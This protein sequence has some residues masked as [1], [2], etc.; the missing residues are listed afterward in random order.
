MTEDHMGDHTR[1]K[2][3]VLVDLNKFLDNGMISTMFVLKVGCE[4]IPDLQFRIDPRRRKILGLSR[5]KK[6]IASL[7]HLLRTLG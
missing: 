5:F 4:K 7:N 6:K 3:E 1:T 2:E